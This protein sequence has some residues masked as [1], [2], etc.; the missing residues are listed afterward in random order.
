MLADVDQPVET[1]SADPAEVPQPTPPGDG[2]SAEALPPNHIF[3]GTVPVPPVRPFD[4]DT[5]PGAD[6]PIGA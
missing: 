5:I 4:L 6:V 1:A 3:V 2:E